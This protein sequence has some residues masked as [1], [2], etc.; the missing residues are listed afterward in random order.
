MEKLRS[1]KYMCFENSF[2][3]E[4]VNGGMYE[5]IYTGRVVENSPGVLGYEIENEDI[6]IYWISTENPMACRDVTGIINVVCGLGKISALC[7]QDM[8]KEAANA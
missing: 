3:L 1:D 5:V 4:S 8:M 6:E 7:V 2:T